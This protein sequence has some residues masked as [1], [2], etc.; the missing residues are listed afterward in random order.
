[1]IQSPSRWLI[2]AAKFAVCR[3]RHRRTRNHRLVA[4]WML[5][6]VPALEHYSL[7]ECLRDGSENSAKYS[8]RRRTR[9]WAVCASMKLVRY[10]RTSSGAS[11]ARHTQDPDPMDAM[12]LAGRRPQCPLAAYR[13]AE[14]ATSP[15][16]VA[17]PSSTALMIFT[18]EFCNYAHRPGRWTTFIDQHHDDGIA[19]RQRRTEQC[20]SDADI[21]GQLMVSCIFT[22]V[23][24]SNVGAARSRRPT[25]NGSITPDLWPNGVQ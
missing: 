6:P 5:T 10:G 19:A 1:M 14:R 25:I 20:R 21:V 2:A 4:D 8:A 12:V 9:S 16:I 24:S 22:S 17:I 13:R 11:S 7:D 18:V 15:G 3:R 23:A